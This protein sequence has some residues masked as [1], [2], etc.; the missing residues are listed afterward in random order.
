[1]IAVLLNIIKVIFIV[2]VVPA[3]GGL[4]AGVDR[5]IS[6]RMQGRVGPPL[7]QP[8]YD[9]F[10]LFAKDS[11]TVNGMTSVYLL[12]SLIFVAFTVT[13]FFIGADLLLVLF[14]LTLGSVFFILGGYSSNS[15]YSLV[16]AERELL[17]VISYEP[18]VL[19]AALGVYCTNHSFYV[20]DIFRTSQ[21]VIKYTPAIFI[22]LLYILAFKLRKSPF[23]LSMSHHAH[24]EIV[25]GITTEFTG[26][27]LAV[28]ELT[29]WYENV[30]VLGLVYIFFAWSAWY[31]NIIALLMCIIV[32]IFEIIIDNSTARV[33]WQMA[34]KT[35]WIVTAVLGGVNLFVLMLIR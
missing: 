12:F 17:Q 19:I 32:Y 4:L 16:G 30:F 11:P 31:S 25:R 26:H 23:D 13:L 2:A 14:A 34:L 28:V 20:S 7:L 27:D 10:K 8:Y 3:A 18:M 5:K 15:P 24:Q 9:L 21:P 33:R 29:H 22:G 1:M 35:S 6:A